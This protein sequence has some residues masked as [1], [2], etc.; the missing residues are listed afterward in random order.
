MSKKYI[1]V[2]YSHSDQGTALEIANAMKTLGYNIWYDAHIQPGNEWRNEIEQKIL[3]SEIMLAFISNKSIESEHCLREIRLAVSGGKRILLIFLQEK[4]KLPND[5]EA[6]LDTQAIYYTRFAGVDSFVSYLSSVECLISC[7]GESLQEN[8]KKESIPLPKTGSEGLKFEKTSLDLSN[9]S[10]SYSMAV[11]IGECDNAHIVVPDL[12]PINAKKVTEVSIKGFQN[13]YIESIALPIHLKAIRTSAFENCKSLKKVKFVSSL[14]HIDSFAFSKCK[15]LEQIELPK[16]TKSLGGYSFYESGLKSIN[17]PSSVSVIDQRAFCNCLSLKTLELQEGIKRIEKDAFSSTAIEILDTPS[18]LK[19]I[20][21][22]AFRNCKSLKAVNFSTGLS[23]IGKNA[24][25]S[26]TSLKELHF[27]AGLK[28][29]G[30]NSFEFTSI[31]ELILPKGLVE[32]KKSAFAFC[33]RLK[34]VVI[35]SGTKI[36]GEQAFAHCRSLEEIYIPAS[37]ISLYKI[38]EG[39]PKRIKIYCEAQELPSDWYGLTYGL[40]KPKIIFGAKIP[41]A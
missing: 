16:T 7:R 30:E 10:I 17:I 29:I 18:T 12:D 33:E 13:S 25:Y 31:E 34:R 22:G 37:V 35:P 24:F 1:F 23:T 14:E 36:I 41:N 21:E 26:C 28:E 40:E 15:S 20:E 5:V 8:E 4:V 6:L 3:N 11:S 38:L 2:S 39:A 9:N 32:V 27:E 19:E